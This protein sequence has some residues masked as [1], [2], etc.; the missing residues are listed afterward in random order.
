[1]SI[2][3]ENAMFSQY[4]PMRYLLA[5]LFAGFGV[6]ELSGRE[7]MLGVAM[8]VFFMAPLIACFIARNFEPK[9][10]GGYDHVKITKMNLSARNFASAASIY[11]FV[12]LVI[13]T[14][15]S[16]L[17]IELHYMLYVAFSV[18]SLLKAGKEFYGYT[19][20]CYLG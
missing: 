5:M 15:L 9:K 1:M 7:P 14:L 11:A 17:G 13:S 19:K 6:D 20:Q 10:L 3:T 16:L 2:D 12:L 8:T 18:I 4:K